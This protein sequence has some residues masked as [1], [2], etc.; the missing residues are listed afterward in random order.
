[1]LTTR[2][3]ATQCNIFTAGGDI[4]EGPIF[5]LLDGSQMLETV[6]R[7]QVLDSCSFIKKILVEKLS[8][9]GEIVG[10]TGDGINEGPALKTAH[11]RFST[12][13]SELSVL[14]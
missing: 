9:L 7:F 13:S 5:R 12:S 10:V 14:E 11:V 4:M 8:V 2:S 6:P 1:M 3:I